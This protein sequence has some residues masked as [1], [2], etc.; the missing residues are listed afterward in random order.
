M[1]TV[2]ESQMFMGRER[3]ITVWNIET[4]AHDQ[5]MAKGMTFCNIFAFF[6]LLQTRYQVWATVWQHLKMNWWLLAERDLLLFG[7]LRL[8][9]VTRKC[10]RAI[11][12]KE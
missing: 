4:G 8:V 12:N 6:L 7:V 11:T 9:L 5:K 1:D 2:C 3:K 10:Q